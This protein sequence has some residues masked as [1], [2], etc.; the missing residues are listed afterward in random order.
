MGRSGARHVNYVKGWFKDTVPALSLSQPV[1]ILRLDGDWYDSTMQCLTG[2][3][4][5]VCSGGIII[6]DDYHF[7][8]GCT[9]A[10]HDFLSSRKLIARLRETPHGVAYIVKDADRRP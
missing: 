10:T 7:W 4:G 6:I 3:Y 9:R 8:E 1:A 2:L 5:Q